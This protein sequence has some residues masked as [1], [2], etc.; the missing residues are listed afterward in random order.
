MGN[1]QST[2]S[3]ETENT[4]RGL[5]M[6]FQEYFDQRYPSK[7]RKDVRMIDL[8]FSLSRQ[9]LNGSLDL[10]EYVNLEEFQIY[11]TKL[12]DL[13]LSN[14]HG[15]K[16]IVIDQNVT[17]LDI[18]IF[19]HLLGLK[20]LSLKN[21]KFYGELKELKR[22]GKLKKFKIKNNSG[23][24]E[25]DGRLEDLPNRLICFKCDEKKIGGEWDLRDFV[26]L[27]ELDCPHNE[28][29]SLNL[30]NCPNLEKLNCEDNKIEKLDLSKNEKLIKLNCSSND[31]EKLNLENNPNLEVIDV[32][33]N[34]IKANLDIF[35]HLTKLRDLEIGIRVLRTG[36]AMIS[37]FMVRQDQLSTNSNFSNNNNFSG[38]LAALS[39]CRDLR[40]LNIGRQ[41]NIRGGLEYLP[42]EKLTDFIY[43]DTE[44]V[45]ELRDLKQKDVQ[46]W[47]LTHP[48]LM[49]R[50]QPEL[51]AND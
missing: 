5:E 7:E 1:E 9:G 6:S 11:N 18:K 12:T 4:C 16:K 42:A 29:T 49:L 50:T 43:N 44:F 31:L 34:K 25:I 22:C 46:A 36:Y 37:K 41:P 21:S 3:T 27:R 24:K 23:V 19:S 48:L 45:E 10:K 26:N 15:L 20:H 35:S 39:N 47:Q 13:N 8:W 30:S 2:S 51:F 33:A 32:K 28:I 14:N 40:R 17:E 38:S